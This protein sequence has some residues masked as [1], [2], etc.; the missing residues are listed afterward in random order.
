MWLDDALSAKV[1][2][3]PQEPGV[4]FH[5]GSERFQAVG[6]GG[7]RGPVEFANS[8]GGFVLV[9]ESARRSRRRMRCVAIA[10]FGGMG[11]WV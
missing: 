1:P 3:L 10:C 8:R 6:E 11:S 2:E 4:H 7:A 9:D 5:S